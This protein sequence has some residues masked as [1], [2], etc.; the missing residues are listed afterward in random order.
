MDN[1]IKNSNNV[2]GAEM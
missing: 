2:M 1:V